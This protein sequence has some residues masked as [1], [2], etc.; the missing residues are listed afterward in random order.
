LNNNHYD[1]KDQPL[2]AQQTNLFSQFIA[3]VIHVLPTMVIVEPNVLQIPLPKFHDGCDAIT[4]IRRLAK[5][6]V[7]NGEDSDAHKL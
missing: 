5:I 3:I 7:M 6:C 4:H 1:K 2:F